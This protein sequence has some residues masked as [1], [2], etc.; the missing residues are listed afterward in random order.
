M[1]PLVRER[2]V[3]GPEQAAIGWLGHHGPKW[4]HNDNTEPGRMP[5]PLSVHSDSQAPRLQ[6]HRPTPAMGVAQSGDGGL[7]VIA[8]ETGRGEGR[9]CPHVC[10]PLGW[11]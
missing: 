6:V 3:Q 7:E 8:G 11:L 2:D 4:G 5:L 9:L 10:C 1:P